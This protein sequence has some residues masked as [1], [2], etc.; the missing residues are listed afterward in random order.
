VTVSRWDAE[1]IL[2]LRDLGGIPGKLDRSD[3]QGIGA[4]TGSRRADLDEGVAKD[5]GGYLAHSSRLEVVRRGAQHHREGPWTLGQ[6]KC[7]PLIQTEPVP[8]GSEGEAGSERHLA[9]INQ[10]PETHSHPAVADDLPEISYA[11]QS[12]ILQV[13]QVLGGDPKAVDKLGPRGIGHFQAPFR[14]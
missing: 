12:C 1:Q 9:G 2:A 14:L 5:D 13:V 10:Q 11:D 6:R 8:A 3:N 4:R 7:R